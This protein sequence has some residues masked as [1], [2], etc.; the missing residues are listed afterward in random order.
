QSAFLRRP[1]ALAALAVTV[2]FIA[3]A[4]PEVTVTG[5]QPARPGQIVATGTYTYRT[6]VDDQDC[7]LQYW[8]AETSALLGT[9]AGP[10]R[11][12][13][14]AACLAPLLD[15]L[16][17][18]HP[19]GLTRLTLSDPAALTGRIDAS[20]DTSPRWNTSRGSP[21]GATTS[22]LICALINGRH[23]AH[24]LGDVLAQ[25]GYELAATTAGLISTGP[26]AGHGRHRLLTGI[27]ILVFTME[28]A[29]AGR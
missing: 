13:Q 3:A 28:R 1:V 21:V 27:S 9:T 15:A 22:E 14:L 20:L 16:L 4:G 6:V 25:R 24:E 26:V 29:G 11:V 17:H 2:V 23:L 10:A 19:G 18:D 5:P 7:T 12:D 8:P